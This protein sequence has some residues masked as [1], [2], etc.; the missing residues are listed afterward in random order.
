MTETKT[1]AKPILSDD[2]KGL[3]AITSIQDAAKF[4][5]DAGI[6]IHSTKEFGDG[7]EITDKNDLVGKEMLIIEWEEKKGDFGPM[8]VVRAVTIDGA[9]VLFVDGSTG[10]LRDLLRIAAESGVTQGLHVPK[11][12]TV[13]DYTYVDDKG[14][15]IPARTY[16]LS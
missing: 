1:V 16:Y 10:V 9:K 7:F 5:M 14:N 4:L 12:L 3:Q 11:G 2:I 6:V 13:S 15:N 8:A